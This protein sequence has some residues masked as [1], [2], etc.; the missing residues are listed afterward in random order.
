MFG[1]RSDGKKVKVTDPIQ[2]LVPHIMN[3]RVASQNFIFQSI[4]CT[5]LDNFI[6]NERELGK[7]YNYMHVVIATIVRVFYLKPELN[8]FVVNGRLFDRYAK[9]GKNISISLT[10]KKHLSEGTPESVIKYAFTGTETLDEIKDLIDQAIRDTTSSKEDALKE[11][12]KTEKTA[13]WFRLMPNGLIKFKGLYHAF[14]QYYL[15]N[16]KSL[17]TD[18]IYHHLYEFGTTSMFISMGKEEELAVIDDADEVAKSKIMKL[19]FTID[20]RISDG[21]YYAKALKLFKKYLTN[22]ELLLQSEKKDD[23]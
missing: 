7:S 17:R 16:M 21:F 23:L 19:G 9:D 20:E 1:L 4:D 11:A 15:T 22:P 14:F 5:N 12:N 18:A 3:S 13:K 2:R 8:R 10:V 6:R